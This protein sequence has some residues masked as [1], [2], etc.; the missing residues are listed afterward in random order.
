MVALFA[1][2]VPGCGLTAFLVFLKA[3]VRGVSTT[4][5]STDG[6]VRA[7]GPVVPKHLA[8]E[9]PKWFGVVSVDGVRS[10]GA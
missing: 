6:W 10:P 7:V 4:A 8:I 9:T 5:D 1:A 3:V 2:G